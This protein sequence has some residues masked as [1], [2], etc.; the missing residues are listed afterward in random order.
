MNRDRDP[1]QVREEIGEGG[2][3]EPS[4]LLLRVA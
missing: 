2:R 1:R 3:T 4:H